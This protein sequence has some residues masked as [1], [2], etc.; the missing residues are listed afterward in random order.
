[1]VQRGVAS[2]H[3]AFSRADP[4]SKVYVQSLI[5]AQHEQVW[6]ALE[7]GAVIYVCGDASRMEPGV[8]RAFIAI[9]CEHSRQDLA[10]GERWLADL[11]AQGR[12]RTDVWAGD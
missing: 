4:A 7:S 5:A 3:R 1:M 12:Y 6:Q 11:L 8:R 9:Y 2:V 10:A